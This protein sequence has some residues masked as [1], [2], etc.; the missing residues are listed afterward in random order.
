MCSATDFLPSVITRFTSCCTSCELWTGSGA[1]ARG[2]I[3]ARL[4]IRL[5]RSVARAS[6]LAVRDAR[7]V[8]RGA[9]DLVADAREILHAA[10]ADE[11][12]R[13]LLEV[14]PLAGDVRRDLHAVGQPDA[15]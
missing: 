14:V 10:A 6:L 7:G 12:D 1:T 2:A 15:R 4:G 8:E 9:D 5:L 3:S 13:V 11:H